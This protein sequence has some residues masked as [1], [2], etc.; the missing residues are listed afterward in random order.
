[1]TGTPTFF[2]N[3]IPIVGARDVGSFADII[4]AELERKQ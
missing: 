1:V 3:G 2:I 4:D